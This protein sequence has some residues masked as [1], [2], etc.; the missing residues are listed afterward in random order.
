MIF[1][2]PCTMKADI[3]SKFSNFYY[4]RE[5]DLHPERLGEFPP[6][7]M[8]EWQCEEFLKQGFLFPSYEEADRARTV[9]LEAY[10]NTSNISPVHS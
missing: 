7:Q 9:M 3:P 2:Y 10:F 6:F 1:V 4:L 5:I 8:E